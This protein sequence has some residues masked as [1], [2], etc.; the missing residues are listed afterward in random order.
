M[1]QGRDFS[2][3]GHAWSGGQ[4]ELKAKQLVEW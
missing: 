1:W 2:T 3:E 4:A